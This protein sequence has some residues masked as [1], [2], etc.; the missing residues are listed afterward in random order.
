MSTCASHILT[1][2]DARS[3]CRRIVS[4]GDVQGPSIRSDE[5]DAL[6][7]ASWKSIVSEQDSVCAYTGIRYAPL[8]QPKAIILDVRSRIFFTDI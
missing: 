3:A 1:E 7:E 2:P 5:G 4:Y 8:N 6:F